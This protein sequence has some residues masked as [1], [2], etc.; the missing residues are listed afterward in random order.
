MAPIGSYY[1]HRTSPVNLAFKAATPAECAVPGESHTVKLIVSLGLCAPNDAVITR[2]GH[3]VKLASK[4]GA[5]PEGLA[6]A[7][8]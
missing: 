4:P 8:W 2:F 5:L 7:P 1:A 6:Q 3:Y